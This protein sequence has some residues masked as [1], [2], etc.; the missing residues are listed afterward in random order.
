MV[1]FAILA[2]TAPVSSDNF[3]LSEKTAGTLDASVRQSPIASTIQAIVLA[4]PITPQVPEL[5]DN[6]FSTNLIF[7]LETSPDLNLDQYLL[8]SVQAPSLSFS[9]LFVIMGPAGRTT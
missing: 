3:N 9:N 7:S 4:V 2:A 1:P 8:Q 5:E 6:L